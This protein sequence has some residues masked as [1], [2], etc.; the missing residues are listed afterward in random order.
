MNDSELSD[1]N[2]EFLKLLG[3][4]R[5]SDSTSRTTKPSEALLDLAWSVAQSYQG[6]TSTLRWQEYPVFALAAATSRESGEPVWLQPE[7][8]SGEEWTLKQEP[9]VGGGAFFLV[10]QVHPGSKDRYVGRSVQVT[11]DDQMYDLGIVS[12][13]G[14]AERRFTGDILLRPRD[15]VVRISDG[16]GKL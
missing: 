16:G 8:N 6:S 1:E 15:T 5:L 2:I 4:V 10:F 11:Y 13:D 12:E 14:I 7:H 3:Q 9:R